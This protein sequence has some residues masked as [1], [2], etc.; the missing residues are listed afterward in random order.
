MTMSETPM[1][2]MFDMQRTVLQQ[3]NQV[4]KQSLTM[5][6]KAFEA[7]RGTFD[8]QRS[9]QRQ[10]VEATRN[11][12]D[13]Y[14][15]ALEDAGANGMGLS[16]AQEAVDQQFDALLDLHDQ[17]WETFEQ[18]TEENA[19]AFDEYIAQLE[20]VADESTRAALDATGQAQ[21]QTEIVIEDGTER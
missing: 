19:A 4:F 12:V 18:L 13:A 6:R 7:F 8:T 2:Q 10:S 15:E 21:E 3:S 16:E 20:T 17:S 11:A 1:T 14:F 5:Q 9:T